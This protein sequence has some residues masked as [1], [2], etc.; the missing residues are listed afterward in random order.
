MFI[1]VYFQFFTLWNEQYQLDPLSTVRNVITKNINE[2]VFIEKL[3]KSN[4]YRPGNG[5]M[6]SKCT[7]KSIKA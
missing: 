3:Q 1:A 5:E 7:K 4:F 6:A 2:L